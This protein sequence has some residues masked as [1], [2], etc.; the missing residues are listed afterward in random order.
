MGDWNLGLQARLAGQ[1][2]ASGRFVL[3]PDLVEHEASA[4]QINPAPLRQW[5]PLPF[6]SAQKAGSRQRLQHRLQ[7]L[8]Q[9]PL[10]L[11]FQVLEI[12]IP[13]DGR[14]HRARAAAL[15]PLRP[16][17]RR[18][19]QQ[20][21]RFARRSA[22]SAAP[23]CAFPWKRRSKSAA[24]GGPI[25]RHLAAVNSFR[26]RW[27]S[28]IPRVLGSEIKRAGGR[29]ASLQLAPPGVEWSFVSGRRLRSV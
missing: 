19:I 3:C 7:L 11:R 5:L 18:G 29:A 9:Q 2:I 8:R 12:R 21:S 10:A 4:A 15:G 16:S 6:L 13:R 22:W 14:F 23:S 20:A 26:G 1:P 24:G 17:T 28:S 27:S 25:V